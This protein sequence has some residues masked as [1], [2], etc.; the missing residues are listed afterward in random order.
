MG[1]VLT[2]CAADVKTGT[3]LAC[4]FAHRKATRP[5]LN[6]VF[7]VNSAPGNVMKHSN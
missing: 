4:T 3:P 5:P 2:I 7:G 1:S 6:L